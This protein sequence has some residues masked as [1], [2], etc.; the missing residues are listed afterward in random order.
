MGAPIGQLCATVVLA[1]VCVVAL[2]AC[3]SGGGAGGAGHR[4][5]VAFAD[6]MRIHGVP[7]FPDPLPTGGF[8]RGSGGSQSPASRTALRACI[9]L[10]R[11][12]SGSRHGPAGAQLAAA[13]KYAR[14]MRA[15]GVPTFSDPV[16]SVARGS[17]NVIVDGGILF[18][19]GTS[20]DPEAPAFQKADAACGGR[21]PGGHPQGG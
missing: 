1:L 21:P 15:H 3:G 7:D 4:A 6:C 18:R 19:L 13:L 11:S 20:I 2:A 14:C 10:L 8:P 16:T 17:T 9:N 12:G 5:D